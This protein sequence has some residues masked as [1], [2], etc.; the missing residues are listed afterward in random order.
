[1]SDAVEKQDDAPSPS[2]VVRELEEAYQG[3]WRLIITD[4]LTFLDKHSNY[5]SASRLDGR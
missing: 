5:Y 1:M 2:E 4:E 3:N